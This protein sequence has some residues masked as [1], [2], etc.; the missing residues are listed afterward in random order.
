MEAKYKKIW[1][2]GGLVEDKQGAFQRLSIE[3]YGAMKA[4]QRINKKLLG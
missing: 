1:G 2:Y 4:K 3:K